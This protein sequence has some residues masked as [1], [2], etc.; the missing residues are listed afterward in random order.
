[1][2]PPLR[3]AESFLELYQVGAR[4]LKLC[5]TVRLPETAL[6]MRLLRI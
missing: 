1:M 6:G 3:L 4:F 2:F 5:L